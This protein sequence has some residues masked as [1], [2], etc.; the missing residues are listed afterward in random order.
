LDQLVITREKRRTEGDRVHCRRRHRWSTPGRARGRARCPLTCSQN[1]KT[2]CG[3]A[4][5][6]LKDEG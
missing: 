6:G 3:N 4:T 2:D 1:Q 5:H